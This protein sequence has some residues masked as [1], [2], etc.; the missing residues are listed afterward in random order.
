M[1]DCKALLCLLSSIIIVEAQQA[2]NKRQMQMIKNA[3]RDRDLNA[4]DQYLD[5]GSIDDYDLF[6]SPG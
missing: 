6:K 5:L 4:I 1:N 2:H 3:S